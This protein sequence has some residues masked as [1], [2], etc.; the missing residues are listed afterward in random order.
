[1]F[2]K[3]V[4]NSGAVRCGLRCRC[5]LDIIRLSIYLPVDEKDYKK[6][7]KKMILLSDEQKRCPNYLQMR[8]DVFQ[9]Y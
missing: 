3:M 8:K 9:S 4:K 5:Y 2:S 1:M 7:E 6:L